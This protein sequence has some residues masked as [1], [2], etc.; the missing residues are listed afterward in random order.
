M[1]I[2][3]KFLGKNE[4]IIE[5]PKTSS[6][7]E[8]QS[9]I[10]EEFD[11][12]WYQMRITNI[13]FLDHVGIENPSR[14]VHLFYDDD[15]ELSFVEFITQQGF[16][17]ARLDGD[18][19]VHALYRLQANHLRAN[20]FPTHP[21]RSFSLPGGANLTLFKAFCTSSYSSETFA[22]KIA[23]LNIPN[24]IPTNFLDPI[25]NE[26]MNTPVIANDNRT[27]DL[28]TLNR[29]NW[30]SPFSRDP[31]YEQYTFPNLSLRAA[32]LRFIEEK[33]AAVASLSNTPSSGSG[34]FT[35]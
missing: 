30:K 1:R 23:A 14:S 29:L 28:E 31:I 9:R 3:V 5:L 4:Q 35:G 21:D 19:T 24:E 26:I 12:K 18:V 25:T 2:T 10:A 20:T 17:N 27:Y 15:P 8:V 34:A 32:I 13:Y 11:C 33:T 6:L 7:R 22:E 16:P